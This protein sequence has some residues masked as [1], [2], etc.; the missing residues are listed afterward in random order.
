MNSR[1]RVLGALERRQIDRVPVNLAC[2]GP[3][4]AVDKLLVHF[5]AKDR[6]DLLV[7]MQIDIRTV[8][9]RYVGPAS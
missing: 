7:K 2:G 3:N 9:P 8:S 1:A 4:S 5:Q 6:E